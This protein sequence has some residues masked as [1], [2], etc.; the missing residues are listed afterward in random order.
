MDLQVIVWLFYY[1]LVPTV[2]LTGRRK[3]SVFRPEV[4]SVLT[5]RAAEVA[6]VNRLQQLQLA[7]A[8]FNKR[9]QT[10]RNVGDERLLGSAVGVPTQLCSTNRC[11][12]FALR[13]QLYV[14]GFVA[15][16]MLF[17]SVPARS[18][19]QL[20]L[21]RLLETGSLV[22]TCDFAWV[23]TSQTGCLCPCIV[24]FSVKG[25]ESMCHENLC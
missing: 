7:H 12:L 4:S 8:N 18:I 15:S 9:L 11:S 5:G 25:S 17:Y 14:L 19:Y 23:R 20:S 16:Q 21:R 2:L 10:R 3:S 13:F 22:V 1:L 24:H 6:A